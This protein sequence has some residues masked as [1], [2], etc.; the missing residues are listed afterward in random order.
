M[1]TAI[2]C[3]EIIRTFP[4]PRKYPFEKVNYSWAVTQLD[5]QANLV[6]YDPIDRTYLLYL[7]RSAR[8]SLPIFARIDSN[9]AKKRTTEAIYT[10][11]T[12]F[13]R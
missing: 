3:K 1:N 2:S 6:R 9:T 5:L 4:Y 8:K 7:Y 10:I 11:V 13:T 12:Y